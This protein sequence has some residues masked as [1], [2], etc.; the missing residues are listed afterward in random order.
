MAGLSRIHTFFLGGLALWALI[1]WCIAAGLV[2]KYRGHY[3]SANAV[4][5]WGI[6]SWLWYLV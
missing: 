5:A 1:T 3:D 6:I 4:L 2:N